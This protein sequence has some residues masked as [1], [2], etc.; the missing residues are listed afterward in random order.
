VRVRGAGEASGETGW[1]MSADGSASGFEITGDVLKVSGEIGLT[2]ERSFELAVKDLM[3]V[4]HGRCVIDLTDVTY[5]N[6]SS[7]RIVAEA[8][9]RANKRG[10]EIKVIAPKKVLRLFELVGVDKLGTFIE[11]AST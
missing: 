2:E 3:I 5:M 10:V 11:A 8:L 6:S 4:D 1:G 7:I 9:A